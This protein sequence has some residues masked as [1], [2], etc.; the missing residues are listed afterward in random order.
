MVFWCYY[1]D[2]LCLFNAS[3]FVGTGVGSLPGEGAGSNPISEIVP[4]RTTYIN[5]KK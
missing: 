2:C 3:N 1:V 5:K 4:K